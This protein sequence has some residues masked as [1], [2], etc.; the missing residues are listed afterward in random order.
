MRASAFGLATACFSACSASGSFLASASD[1]PMLVSTLGS[2][3]AI[4][5][6]SR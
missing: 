1:S 4:F 2:P 3:G 5:S 6:A